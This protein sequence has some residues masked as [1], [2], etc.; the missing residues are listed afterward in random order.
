MRKL[1]E[2]RSTIDGCQAK[3]NKRFDQVRQIMQ[4][5]EN[6]GISDKDYEHYQGYNDRPAY[7]LAHNLERA[8]EEDIEEALDLC[9]VL[10]SLKQPKR[11]LFSRKP[12]DQTTLAMLKR[13]MLKYYSIVG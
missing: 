11:W 7:G 2:T 10:D 1:S 8:K 3:L 4:T 5:L 13:L 12:S 9:A 6:Y